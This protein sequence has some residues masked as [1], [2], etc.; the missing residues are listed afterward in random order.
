MDRDELAASILAQLGEPNARC[1]HARDGREH[2]L[3]RVALARGERML[4]IPRKDALVDPFDATRTTHERLCGESVAI[5]LARGVPV[6]GHYEVH[7]TAPTS[8]TMDVLPGLT[9]E[10]ALEKGQLD[11]E[12]LRRVC[13]QMGRMLA[14]LHGVRKTGDGGELPVLETTASGNAR[15]L[16]LDYHLGNVLGRPRLGGDWEVTGV[17]DWT[18]ARW[19]PPEADFVEMQVSV[20]IRNPRARDAF[21]AGYRQV[22][23]RAVNLAE[24]ELRAAREIRRRLAENPD[25]GGPVRG[26][27]TAFAARYPG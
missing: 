4:K 13:L 6:P 10:Q 16:H 25:E 17:V 5:A 23:A 8:A 11:E 7:L 3:F 24:V 2:H 27:W 19:G 12:Q 26:Y 1:V 22:A 14:H 20:F 21:V 18:C 9:A 15:L